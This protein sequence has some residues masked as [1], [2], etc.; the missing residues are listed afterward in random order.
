MKEQGLFFTAEQIELLKEIDRLEMDRLKSYIEPYKFTGD[1]NERK[2]LTIVNRM[3]IAEEI[4]VKYSMLKKHK[5]IFHDQLFSAMEEYLKACT[6]K[7]YK[8]EGL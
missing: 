8:I 1:P 3:K 5:G 2:K 7:G 6:E 4:Q